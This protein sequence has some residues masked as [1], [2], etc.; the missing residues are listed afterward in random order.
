MNCLIVQEKTQEKVKWTHFSKSTLLDPWKM[1]TP[2]LLH[3]FRS[4]EIVLFV[5][6]NK[7]MLFSPFSTTWMMTHLK[8]IYWN[9]EKCAI[10]SVA[11]QLLFQKNA[12]LA[13]C[14]GGFD[15]AAG[16]N[17]CN[18]MIQPLSTRTNTWIMRLHRFARMNEMFHLV[19]AIY[20]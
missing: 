20:V 8:F 11:Y 18:R 16:A 6:A 7:I 19:N 10:H 17:Q 14:A 12:I 4:Y 5:P 13:D 15:F 3:G 2:F 9:F 1:T